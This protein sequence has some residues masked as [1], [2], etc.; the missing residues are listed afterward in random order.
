MAPQTCL[1]RRIEFFWSYD[2]THF[3]LIAD[4]AVCDRYV[5][6]RYVYDRYVCDRHVC[7]RYVYF[8]TVPCASISSQEE[9]DATGER[10]GS[11]MH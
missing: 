2:Q 11:F 1:L 5:C 10:P 4:P 9:I 8:I 6:D 3:Y 7:D